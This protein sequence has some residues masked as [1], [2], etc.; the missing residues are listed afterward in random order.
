MCKLCSVIH[1]CIIV[2][3]LWP[4]WLILWLRFVW[5]TEIKSILTAADWSGCKPG[6]KRRRFLSRCELPNIHPEVS[7]IK[8]NSIYIGC[9]SIYRMVQ[10]AKTLDFHVMHIFHFSQFLLDFFQ[11]FFLYLEIINIFSM[12]WYRP[13]VQHHFFVFFSEYSFRCWQFF[14]P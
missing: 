4:M 2:F 11:I 3:C 8:M 13:H 14:L 1:V 7:E 9:C 6:K 12:I 5:E 10:K